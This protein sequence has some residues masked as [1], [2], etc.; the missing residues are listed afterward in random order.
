MWNHVSSPKQKILPIM[1]YFQQYFGT[2]AG[3]APTPLARMELLGPILVH[4]FHRY[5]SRLCCLVSPT[6][7]DSSVKSSP[8]GSRPPPLH[9]R[10][11]MKRFPLSGQSLN[12]NL[13]LWRNVLQNLLS[14][15]CHFGFCDQQIHTSRSV[16]SWN[17]NTQHTNCVFG[18]FW[19]RKKLKDSS[20]RTQNG[21]ANRMVCTFYGGVWSQVKV[22]SEVF[23]RRNNFS[24]KFEN[25]F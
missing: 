14:K 12:V 16:G 18:L 25:W 23:Q 11:R 24:A 17:Y 10:G 3:V 4:V 9:W 13:I 20:K 7:R 6:S 15:F 19:C 8:S 22:L 5:T 21:R 1:I 2:N